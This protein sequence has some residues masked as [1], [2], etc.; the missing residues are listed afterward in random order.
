MIMRREIWA[1]CIG[2]MMCGG[3]CSSDSSHG[4]LD[5]G[6]SG[7]AGDPAADSGRKDAATSLAELDSGTPF[8]LDAGPRDAGHPPVLTP[9]DSSVAP[10]AGSGGLSSYD[11]GAT[12]E[13]PE[14]SGSSLP[15]NPGPCADRP[16][17]CDLLC[18]Q[19]AR[20]ACA[21]AKPIPECT[22]MCL[23]APATCQTAAIALMM[24]QVTQPEANLACD[25]D[26]GL[27]I[28]SGCLDAEVAV[29]ACNAG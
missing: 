4:P 3:A 29:A 26:F 19:S 23:P 13:D 12:P 1:A 21:D 20:A 2:L 6:T 9:L 28:I 24:C 14:D 5:S 16:C 18:Q 25:L 15:A 17:L 22:A 27:L 10:A 11:A 8:T 7:T